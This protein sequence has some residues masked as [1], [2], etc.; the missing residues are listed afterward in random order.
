[1]S[2]ERARWARSMVWR[3]APGA[4]GRVREED[5]GIEF[6]SRVSRHVTEFVSRFETRHRP[7]AKA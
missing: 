4:E 3:C 1:M 2:K 7:R 6:E 5:I